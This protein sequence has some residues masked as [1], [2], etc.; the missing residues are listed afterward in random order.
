LK[1]RDDPAGRLAMCA[2]GYDAGDG[3]LTTDDR[4]WLSRKPI[5]PR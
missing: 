5:I 4:Q 2:L 3:R 1:R